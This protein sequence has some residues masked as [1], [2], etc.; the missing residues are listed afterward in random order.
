MLQVGVVVA[1]LA[2][3]ALYAAPSAVAI[4]KGRRRW[5][6]VLAINILLGWSIVGW[7][8]A[9]A[10]AL[11]ITPRR[12]AWT[13]RARK[14]RSKPATAAVPTERDEIPVRRDA[15]D[16]PEIREDVYASWLDQGAAIPGSSQ[17]AKSS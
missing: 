2:A 9:L 12:P 10:I 14:P 7:L 15:N 3:S 16:P 6:L 4:L 1:F 5:L 8:L 13:I 17:N 11:D